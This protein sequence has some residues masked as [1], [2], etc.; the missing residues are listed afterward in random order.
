VQADLVKKMII[1]KFYVD[2][3]V[4]ENRFTGVSIYA[5]HIAAYLE[6]NFDCTILVPSYFARDFR[7]TVICPDPIFFKETLIGRSPFMRQR[8]GVNFGPDSFVYAPHMHGYIGVGNQVITIHDVI[9]KYHKTRSAFENTFNAYILPRIAR[10]AVG[11][12][13]VSQTSRA[14]IGRDLQIASEK[15]AVV[16]NGLDLQRWKPASVLSQAESPA[17]LLAVS[18]NRPYKNTTELIK[19]HELWSARF[20]LKIVCN[21]ADYRAVLKRAVAAA[22][23]QH[24][25]DFYD[26][27]SEDALIELYQNCV[28]AV[29]PSSI[30][31]FGRPALEAMAVGR[32]I[33]LSDIPVHREIFSTSAIFLTPGDRASW[34]RAFRTLDDHCEL[35]RL[36]TAGLVLARQ[37]GWNRIGQDLKDALLRFEPQLALLCRNP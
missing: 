15:I 24:R 3:T 2:L 1:R 10:R 17:Y 16:G 8:A 6:E 33:I 19:H 30:E 36:V 4:L 14:E 25:V 32:P 7:H 37:F 29:Y 31:G 12:V 21:M 23:L 28:A 18:A 20:R 26:N 22:G 11:I 34:E 13:T 35:E 5:K 9:H 27:V